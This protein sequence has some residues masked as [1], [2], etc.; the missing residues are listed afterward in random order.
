VPTDDGRL[1]SPGGGL[2]RARLDYGSRVGLRNKGMTSSC[3]MRT[4]SRLHASTLVGLL[5]VIAI[6]GILAAILIQAIDQMAVTGRQPPA[7][8][9][10]RQ[11]ATTT[12]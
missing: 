4:F 10:L 3:I 7:L 9:K 6:I 1:R 8:S 5:P 2:G 11:L 12:L